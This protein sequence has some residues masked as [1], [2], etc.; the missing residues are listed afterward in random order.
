M[1]AGGYV[2]HMFDGNGTPFTIDSPTKTVY[3]HKGSWNE[4]CKATGV[5]ND[6]GKA[7]LWYY[8]NAGL[9]CV[10][11][12]GTVF[13]LDWQETVSSSGVATLSCHFNANQA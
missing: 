1:Q 6:T 7:V 10:D 5:A 4:T 8:Y 2:C 9:P 13:T 11:A 12:R 3:T